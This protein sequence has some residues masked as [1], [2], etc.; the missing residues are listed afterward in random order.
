MTDQLAQLKHAL[1]GTYAVERQIGAGG[2][3]S[4]Y[5]ARDL[6]HGRAVAI[7]VLRPEL[8]ASVGT[9]R[10]LR[11]IEM[12]ARL[13][14]PHILAVYDSGA[15][16]GLL[17][18][19]M[20]FVEGESL[21]DRLDRD[22]RLP[23]EETIRL[24]REVASALDYAHSNGVVHRDIK[25]ENILLFGGHAVVADFG[26]ARAVESGGPQLTGMGMAIG[27]PAYMSPEQ[28]TAEAEID[29]RSDQYSLACVIYE[30][31]T[32]ER[33]FGGPTVQSVITR[34]ISGPRPRVRKVRPDVP[35]AT[36]GALVRALDQDPKKRFPTATAFADALETG[37]SGAYEA[38][39]RGSRRWMG[40]AAAAV[41]VLAGFVG[42]TALRGR[43]P[44]VEAAQRIA[45]LPF[46]TSGPDVQLLGEGLVDL[47]STN[48]DGV[49]GI[50]AVEPRTVLQR[51]QQRGSSAALDDALAVAGD[52]DAGAVLLGSVIQ[53]GQSVR[54]AADLYARDGS[55]LG[56]AQVDGPADSVL[57]L[58]DGLSL[59][60]MREV[61]R[62]SEPLPSLR[63][64]SMTTTSPA[65]MR[66]YLRGEQ[67]Y[68]RSEWDSA[69]AAYRDAVTD[70]STFALAHYRLAT[71]YG[72]MGNA[73]NEEAEAAGEAAVRWASRLPS[74][75]QTI[76]KAYRAF[77]K[78]DV[79]ATDTMLR[80]TAAHPDDVD[81]WY[82]LGESQFHR[83]SM[84]PMTPEAIRA[85]F[86][87]VIGLDSSLA[88]AVIH[89][90]DLALSH[91]DR[92]TYQ[93]F[94]PV[95]QRSGASDQVRRFRSME[96]IV[97]SDQPVDTPVA[98]LLGEG[99]VAPAIISFATLIRN[100][101]RD[102]DARLARARAVVEAF[103]EEIRQRSQIDM[104]LGAALA[105]MGRIDGALEVAS[106]M[107][108]LP[109]AVP[110]IS[111]VPVV[112]G[113]APPGYA[114]SLRQALDAQVARARAAGAPP[115]LFVSYWR[116]LFLLGAGDADA[117]AAMLERARTL[118]REDFPQ[119]G[120]VFD[121]LDAARGALQVQQG[122]T[123]AGLARL[124]AGLEASGMGEGNF[125][126]APLR[127]REAIILASRPAS[128]D[129]G[130]LMLQYGFD[131][132]PQYAA[133][134]QLA[135]GEAYEAKGDYSSAA[136]AYTEFLELWKK[137]DPPYQPRVT[138]VR[139]ALLR[140]QRAGG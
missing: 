15:A 131:Y 2:M 94:M 20:P 79:A 69:A 128:R 38:A 118:K 88:P 107:T 14:H 56:H 6:K 112:G 33:A 29:G 89:P 44:V 16:A 46:R 65:A 84:R 41:L 39:A 108:W 74:N 49:G 51:W 117:A 90:L 34:S 75:D 85:P 129:E 8:S 120:F 140:V 9:D 23:V 28:A 125:M 91:N 11:E 10:F 92:E 12:A 13:Q 109:D 61:W 36:D 103:P 71:T 72:W 132:D 93:R 81:G 126:S 82:L 77:Q 54:L 115:G 24:A 42:W 133:M 1:Q 19:V 40:I 99:Q 58:V 122:D 87:R 106:S 62:S 66:D 96:A 121:L 113:F 80:Y 138:Q 86:E 3:A 137:A 53:T 35:E 114:D 83:R 98:R 25:P 105:G 102:A 60:L 100:P 123:V 43:P 21:R 32:A 124:R 57:S 110:A 73:N 78:G 104:L 95:L 111:V 70:D 136:T 45:V 76:V 50:E 63:V 4:V 30:M 18:Y 31:L 48:L 135:L 130:I 52:V 67:F 139:E 101:G 97:W 26:V 134:V 27:T 55:K 37:R 127:L 68:R 59:A 119:Q 22:G 17:Y 5:L 64:A 116:S 47:L 7:K